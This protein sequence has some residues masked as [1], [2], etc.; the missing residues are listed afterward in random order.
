VLLFLIA[1]AV[2]SLTSRYESNSEKRAAPTFDNS[3][4][5]TNEALR[6]M[7]NPILVFIQRE[8]ETRSH[9]DTLSVAFNKIMDQDFTSKL[10]GRHGIIVLTS[11]DPALSARA[12]M[13]LSQTG[14]D[15]LY[16]LK[17]GVLQVRD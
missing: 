15:S 14:V 7:P 6:R 12:W 2:K 8:N 11:D 16:I 17:E 3:N 5:I 9:G 13:I 4:F 1:L 10:H